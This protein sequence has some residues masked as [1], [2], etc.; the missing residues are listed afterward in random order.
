MFSQ[1][2]A[3]VKGALFKVIIFK[4]YNK[5]DPIQMSYLV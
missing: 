1:T 3:N 4:E 5:V 2:T